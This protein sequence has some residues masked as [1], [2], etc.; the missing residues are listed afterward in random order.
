MKKTKLSIRVTDKD[1]KTRI[2][3]SMAAAARELN[4]DPANIRKVVRGER[5]SAGG[6]Q[7]AATSEKP[8]T[9]EGRRAARQ[10]RESANRKDIINTVHDRLK[11]LNVRFRNARK[12]DAFATDPVLQQL[13]SHTGYFGQT[14]TGGYNISAQNLKKF[15][16]TELENLMRVLNAEE[17]KYTRPKKKR[18]VSPA[19]LAATFGIS[20]NQV[21]KYDYLV[22]VLFDLLHLVKE[23]AFFKYAEV[24]NAIFNVMQNDI[25]PEKLEEYIDMIYDAYMGN[26]VDDLN[27]I[28]DQM[29]S[30]GSEFRDS[31]D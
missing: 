11:E 21:E 9:K 1:G 12:T 28:V 27:N 13:M 3:S 22:P 23:E 25:E 7:F 17:K 8:T 31:Y 24:Q 19:R 16:N 29:N 14:K 18:E 30:Y 15:S 4:I 26:R 10:A 6:Y 20:E 5:K 2:F